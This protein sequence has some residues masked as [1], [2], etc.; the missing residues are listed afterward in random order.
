[1]MK[2]VLVALLAGGVLGAGGCAS[3]PPTGTETERERLVEAN[4]RAARAVERG[5]LPR[6]AT[7]YRQALRVAESLEDFRGIAINALNLAATCQ[8]LDD[9]VCARGALDRILRVPAHFEPR[10]ISE[11]AGRE[12]QIALREGRLDAAGASLDRAERACAAPACRN[13]TAL[14]NLRAEI[15]LERGDAGEAQT[16]AARS[17]A[18]SRAEGN[19]EEEANAL[20]LAGRAASQAGEHERALAQLAEALALDKQLALP[21]KIALDLIAL[22]EAELARGDR[23]AAGDYALRALSVSRATGSRLLVQR[24]EQLVERAR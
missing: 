20:R 10:W 2:G 22:A 17:L 7:L 13:G 21:R 9:A 1:M 16:V 4:A 3:P 23:D 8:A 6:A 18:A 24:S 15:L 12:T 14:V 11:A 5:D 19:R